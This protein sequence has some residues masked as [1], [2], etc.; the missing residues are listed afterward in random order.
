MKN[1]SG[2]R[3]TQLSNLDLKWFTDPVAPRRRF[4]CLSSRVKAAETRHLVPIIQIIWRGK[5][6]VGD[7][8]DDLVSEVLDGLVGCYV[9]Q[10]AAEWTLDMRDTM[11]EHLDSMAESYQQLSSMALHAVPVK[12]LWNEVPK[13][14]Y[15]MHLR[16]QCTWGNPR[17]WWCYP[18]ED[19]L[20]I[21]SK[22]TA[23]CTKGTA[24][25]EVV[26]KAVKKWMFGMMYRL[27]A[28]AERD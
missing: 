17:T 10:D 28:E 5:R 22:L 25:T 16:L 20:G 21:V 4:P 18:A 13:H 2:A 3:P 24:T 6:A 7:P 27:R 14:H 12:R 1:V 23:S 19:Y 9:C 15:T 26:R 8:H 11:V